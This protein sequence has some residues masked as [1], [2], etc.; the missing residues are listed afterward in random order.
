MARNRAP[1]TQPSITRAE[2]LQALV[3]SGYLLES[4][5]ESVLRSGTFRVEANTMVPDTDGGLRE[6]DLWARW[7]KVLLFGPKEDSCIGLELVIECINPPQPVAFIT[8]DRADPFFERIDR[9]ESLKLVGNPPEESTNPQH[10]WDWL[11]SR[12]DVTRYHH[13]KTKRVATQ[14]CSF[15]KKQGSMQWMALH[16]DEDHQVFRKLCYSTDHF[17]RDLITPDYSQEAGW[18]LS[19]VY[20]VLVVQGD[21]LDVRPTT[22]SARLVRVD[23]IQ[24]CCTHSAHGEMNSYQIDVV[25]EKY[26]P[27]YLTMLFRELRLMHK[28]LASNFGSLEEFRRMRARNIR[29][30]AARNSDPAQ[31]G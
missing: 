16:R 19:L 6:L 5:L 22:R 11:P 12:L 14:Y 18:D 21:I 24:Y 20:P 29:L 28:R 10:M 27:K 7:A 23:H 31:A 2:A 30:Y 4:R 17:I 3:R 9:W 15:Q 8:K 13:Y 26:F 25:T 1:E